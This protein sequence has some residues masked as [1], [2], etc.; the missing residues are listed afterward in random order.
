[1]SLSEN[2]TEL[3]LCPWQREGDNITVSGQVTDPDGKV[4]T[5][6]FRVPAS[7]EASLTTSA[8]P[9]VIGF[10]F[11]CMHW[12]R[13]VHIHGVASPSLLANLELL[14]Q[15]W[16]QRRPELYQPLRFFADEERESVPSCS[17]EV[18]ACFSG[19]VDSCYTFW[20]HSQ[21]LVGRRNC[22]LN[23]GLLVQGF[24]DLPLD[25]PEAFTEAKRK[26][27]LIL[28][29]I[30]VETIPL[31]TNAARDLPMPGHPHT[32]AMAHATSIGAI[33]H[34]FSGRFQH[35]LIANS[36]PYTAIDHTYGTSPLTD[37]LMSGTG[38]EIR[39]DG[40]EATRPQKLAAI[41]H[42]KEAMANLRVCNNGSNGDNCCTCEKCLR[43]IMA[44]RLHLEK[45]PP[46]FQLAATSRQIR[47]LRLRYPGKFFFWE[48]ILKDAQAKGMGQTEW[49]QAINTALR[50][51]RVRLFRKRLTDPIRKWFCG[52]NQTK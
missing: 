51:S 13:P 49:A 24:A 4:H 15:V 30:G 47:D 31:A 46:C 28:D 26:C 12:N 18:I 21:K 44:L 7:Q 48:S 10:L 20:R 23:T 32:W 1:M 16:H 42:W 2:S 41:V 36:D 9:F 22:K 45:Q 40:G 34:L 38:M 8:D 37:H 19:G 17:D 43:T 5:L 14:S 39:D 6:W 33:L 25:Q 52:D 29:S 35:G 3:I 27:R 11:P 50:L